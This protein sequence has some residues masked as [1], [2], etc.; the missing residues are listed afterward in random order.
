MDELNPNY[1]WVAADM[2]APRQA[3]IPAPGS[4]R[5]HLNFESHL[6]L[7]E[8]ICKGR[9]HLLLVLVLRGGGCCCCGGGGEIHL[10]KMS[11]S[12]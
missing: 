1:V 8:G 12:G 7:I 6:C 4:S 3:G 10:V 9:R 2:S 5:S 11:G